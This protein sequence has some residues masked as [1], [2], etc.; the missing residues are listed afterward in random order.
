LSVPIVSL[1]A[2]TRVRF[3][4]AQASGVGAGEAAALPVGPVASVGA[5]LGEAPAVHAATR[6]ATSAGAATRIVIRMVVL[7][8]RV[9]RR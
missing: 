8:L 5:G 7:L 9:I 3:N 4:L 6:T 1:P 2:V